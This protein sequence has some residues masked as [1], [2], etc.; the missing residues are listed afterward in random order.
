MDFMK[1]GLE[2]LMLLYGGDDKRIAEDYNKIFNPSDAPSFKEPDSW[3]TTCLYIGG[4][5]SKLETEIYK[6]F[7]EGE[8]VDISSSTLVYVPGKILSSPVFFKS[9]NLIDNKFPHT[10]LLLGKYRAVDSN[11]VLTSLFQD[12]EELKKIYERGDI[13]ITSPLTFNFKVKDV[14]IKFDDLKKEE[15]VDAVYMIKAGK[16]FVLD[17]RT[18][19]I[20]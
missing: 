13:N 10:T 18:A 7:K 16:G 6:K 17:G 20:Y 11:Y 5:R 12:N 4:D 14:T 2:Q 1:T 3:H 19:K 8:Q 9:F 15:K